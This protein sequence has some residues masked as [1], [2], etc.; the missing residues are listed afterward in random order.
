GPG[1][2]VEKSAYAIHYAPDAPK[3]LIRERNLAGLEVE[4]QKDN[5]LL[6]YVLKGVP[7]Y[8]Q[9]PLSPSPAA[10]APRLSARLPNFQYKGYH[11]EIGDWGE[12]GLWLQQLFKGRDA[13]DPTSQR[14][15]QKL[16]E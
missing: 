10:Y 11:A 5:G 16:V 2:S 7:A 14:T 12:M 8:V 3:P 13:L 6:R 15:V 9:E 1:I 4:R